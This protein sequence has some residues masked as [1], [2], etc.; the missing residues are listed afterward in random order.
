MVGDSGVAFVEVE[1]TNAMYVAVIKNDFPDIDIAYLELNARVVADGVV[2]LPD[3][4]KHTIA[5]EPL[6]VFEKN[7]G[8]VFAE[9]YLGGSF[10]SLK[11]RIVSG[12]AEEVFFKTFNK[13]IDYIRS[14][15]KDQ[16]YS[17][18]HERYKKEVDGFVVTRERIM[19]RKYFLIAYDTSVCRYE[20]GQ[21]FGLSGAP[22]ITFDGNVVG[23]IVEQLPISLVYE[24]SKD[25][26]VLAAVPLTVSLPLFN[27]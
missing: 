4:Q 12:M 13:L 25:W 14:L 16:S 18:N 1:S 9:G 22:I 19:Q 20:P 5:V 2:K 7:S 10:T 21:L 3:V 15:I 26:G 17:M 24:N 11:C 23:T 8:S 6:D 27:K